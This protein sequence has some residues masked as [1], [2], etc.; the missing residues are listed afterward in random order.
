MLLISLQLVAAALSL[1]SMWLYARKSLWGPGLSVLDTV[2]WA[3]LAYLTHTPVTL[4]LDL[5]LG[6]LSVR[7]FI[8]WRRDAHEVCKHT[9]PH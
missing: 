5:I 9:K 4:A 3:V 7:T 1:A 8:T 2:P 6:V